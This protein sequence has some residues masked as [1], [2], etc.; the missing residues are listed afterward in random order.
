[1][2]GNHMNTENI[3]MAKKSKIQSLRELAQIQGSHGN[4]NHDPY[5]LGLYNGLELGLSIMEKREPYYKEA[6]E[7]WIAEMQDDAI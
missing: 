4:W 1:M 7:K 3:L 2:T 5:M 6:P